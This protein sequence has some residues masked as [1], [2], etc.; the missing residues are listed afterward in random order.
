MKVLKPNNYFPKM[1]AKK[2]DSLIHGLYEAQA[3]VE[4][5]AKQGYSGTDKALDSLTIVITNLT[6]IKVS[7]KLK[8]T[9]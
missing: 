3:I 9:P 1:D 8:G 5:V 6:R 7:K 2:L 4:Q